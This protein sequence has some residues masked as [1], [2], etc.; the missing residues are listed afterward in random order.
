MAE[1]DILTGENFMQRLV[2]ATDEELENWVIAIQAAQVMA[3]RHQEDMAVLSNYR[4]V[5]LATNDEPPLEIIR[6][7]P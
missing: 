6:Y 5:K 2:R 3:T 4:V 7:S 1:T